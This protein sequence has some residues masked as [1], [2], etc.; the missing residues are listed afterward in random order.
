VVV[1]TIKAAGLFAAGHVAAAGAI[2]VKVAAL[3][4][5]VLKAML[6]TKL[7]IATAVVL[8]AALVCSSAGLLSGKL[9]GA[10]QAEARQTTGPGKAQPSDP[11]KPQKAEPGVVGVWI[12]HRD[13]GVAEGDLTITFTPDGKIKY[14]D[15]RRVEYGSYK[16]NAKKEPPEIDVVTPAR[17][18]P[19]NDKPALIGIYRIEGPAL[20][21]YLAEDKR[22]TKYE[23]PDGS[24]VMRWVLERAKK[25]AP[26][27]SD[28]EGA[29]P[30]QAEKEKAG[31]KLNGKWKTVTAEYGARP[32]FQESWR[33]ADGKITMR[34]LLGNKTADNA[35]EEVASFKID[36][37]KKPAHIDIEVD[38]GGQQRVLKGIYKLD[39]DTLTVCL[40]AAREGDED[41]RPSEF[42]TRSF[43]QRDEKG[44]LY[45]FTFKREKD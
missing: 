22:P 14:D 38:R 18:N 26:K 7:K 8:V 4:D 41:G 3:T 32:F 43:Q 21:M 45:L 11:E 44:G 30:K 34:K 12:E 28:P 42:F 33:I 35:E 17:A 1:S 27:G 23:A 25:D 6:L 39:G 10:T 16:L 19:A 37:A 24:G 13:N 15:G 31:A 2:S 36:P 5:G 9:T 20:T 40:I 29:A